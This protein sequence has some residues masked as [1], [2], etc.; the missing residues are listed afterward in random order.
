M[1]SIS[2]IIPVYNVEKYIRSCVESIFHQGMDEDSFEVILVNDGT[3]DKSMDII[4]DI[5]SS[6]SNVTVI[7]QQNQGLSVA[8]NNG[9]ALAKGEYILFVDSDDKLVENSLSQLLNEALK[10]DVDIAVAEFLDIE[11]EKDIASSI[12]NIKFEEISGRQLFMNGFENYVWHK[13]YKKKFLKENNLY[14]IPGLFF[15][16]IPFTHECY[17]KVKK[18]ITS[19]IVL[20]LY[21]KRAGSITRSPFNKD[22]ISSAITAITKL[23]DFEALT[24][25]DIEQQNKLY[26]NIFSFTS[27]F[28]CTVIHSDI[29]YRDRNKIIDSLLE[30]FPCIP[31]KRGV[32]QKMIS[33]ILQK[34]PHLY[35]QSRY[36]Y[37]KVI[38]DLFAPKY[39]KLKNKFSL[40]WKKNRKKSS[41]K[42]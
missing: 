39:R 6:H 19:N 16:D 31:F 30:A 2:I 40:I 11:D 35:I 24:G 26:D 32:K 9:L 7:N 37:G 10:Y 22:R 36:C 25:N 28:I 1:I 12:N 4:A 29:C 17:L 33:Y 5:I 8:R 42:V 27:Q 14:F 13:I 41:I 18:C 3:E 38:E 20:Y 21:R 15:E 34:M 23:F